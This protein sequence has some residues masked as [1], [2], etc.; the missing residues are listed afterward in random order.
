MP[1]GL[2]GKHKAAL[3]VYRQALAL[4]DDDWELWHNAGL[5][6][7]YLQQDDEAAEA[8][9]KANS[10]CRHDDTFLQ[11]GQEYQ[12]TD[13]KKALRLYQDALDFSP[14]NPQ[15]LC[16]IG[17]AYMRLNDHSR[18]FEYLGTAL[19]YDP[20]NTKAILAAGSIVQDNG[21]MDVALHKYRIAAVHTPHSPQLWNNVAMALFGKSKFLAAISCLT[22]A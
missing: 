5:C 8:F 9:C 10:L 19:T 18:A 2:L 22:R 17:L 21:E 13:V 7:T 12:K 1:T 3:D 14:E 11:L 15:I 4:T 16:A 6:Y 20:T